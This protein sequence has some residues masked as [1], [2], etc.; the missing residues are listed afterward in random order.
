MSPDLIVWPETSYPQDWT[1]I[2]PELPPNQV[3][4]DWRRDQAESKE[5][6]RLVASRWKTDVL[7]GINA[8]E[9]GADGK[10]S[11]YNSAVLVQKDGTPGVRRRVRPRESSNTR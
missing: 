8:V 10:R 4:A 9:L 1:E 5:L 11:R 7:L 2:S 3:P 6:A